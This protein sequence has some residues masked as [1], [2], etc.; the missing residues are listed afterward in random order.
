MIVVGKMGVGKSAFCNILLGSSRFKSEDSLSAVTTNVQAGCA[1]RGNRNVFVIDTP[2]FRDGEK[3]SDQEVVEMAGHICEHF[4]RISPGFHCIVL[5]LNAD[6]RFT[7]EDKEIVDDVKKVFGDDVMHHMILVFTRCKDGDD[8]DKLTKTSD[9]QF[10]GLL[11]EIN[12][13]VF[14]IFR[15]CTDYEKK[16]HADAFFKMV[17]TLCIDIGALYT[18]EMLLEAWRLVESQIKTPQDRLKI[19]DLQKKLDS[20]HLVR[21]FLNLFRT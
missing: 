9:P 14:P 12:N 21:F 11:K 1:D 10:K 8:L 5:V 17:D 2:G 18:N 6:E 16:D 19:K 3:T 7:R 4:L 15:D 20:L 13:R